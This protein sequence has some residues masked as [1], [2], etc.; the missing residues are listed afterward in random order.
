MKKLALISD[1]IFTFFVSFLLSFC[2]F[3][4]LGILFFPA[5]LLSGICALLCALSL[6]AFLN[7][8]RKQ[9]FLKK[10]DETQK[11]K[12]LL[13]LA[14]STPQENAAFFENF[15][16]AHAHKRNPTRLDSEEKTYLLR[17]TLSPVA[18]DDITSFYRLKS[19]PKTLLCCSVNAEACT[20]CERFDIEIL[21]ADELYVALKKANAL[22]VAY[23]GE[24]TT[25]K[26]AK[27]HFKLWFS[28]ANSKR[29]LV[30]AALIVFASLL[31][32][33]SYYYLVFGAILLLC[34]VFVRIFGYE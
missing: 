2:I 14:L 4:Y 25:K 20:L 27:R 26:K 3:R 19:K 22:P 23:L 17:F 32:P 16:N 21:T 7:A 12:L 9:F 10:S 31:T 5:I 29:F 24:E 1:L 34:A 18:P 11:Q 28:K 30:S 15:L 33:F 13:H 8:R 6:G